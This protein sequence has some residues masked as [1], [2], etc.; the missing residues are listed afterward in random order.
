MTIDS[1][2]FSRVTSKVS[3]SSIVVLDDKLITEDTAIEQE[4]RDSSDDDDGDD[5]NGK[6]VALKVDNNISKKKPSVIEGDE[7]P[8]KGDSS[9][10]HG[11]SSGSGGGGTYSRSYYQSELP[12]RLQKKLHDTKTSSS[13][14]RK[15]PKQQRIKRK[16]DYVTGKKWDFNTGKQSS[17]PRAQQ[18]NK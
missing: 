4:Q 18:V 3:G 6:M 15:P 2:F 16:D 7:L 14:T 13:I 5:L 10:W 17:E 11:N 12:P 1:A 9:A 8:V